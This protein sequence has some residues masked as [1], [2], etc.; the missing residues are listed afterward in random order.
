[1]AVIT[2]ARGTLEAAVQLGARLSESLGCR[3]VSREEV[4]E[5]AKVYGIEETGLGDM[6]FIDQRAP[7]FWHPFSGKR[8]QYLACFQTAL[9]DLVLQGDLVYVGHLAHLLLSG[10]RRV[11]RVRLAAPDGYRVEMLVRT[12]SMTEAHAKAYIREIDERRLRWSQFLYGVDW[13]TPEL[14]DMVLNPDKLR[15]ETMTRAV[16]TIAQSIEMQPTSYDREQLRSLR[17]KAV[18]KAALLRSPRTRG[19][20]VTIEADVTSGHVRVYGIAPNI[21]FE[22]WERDLRVTLAE[23]PGVRTTEIVP[24][25]PPAGISDDLGVG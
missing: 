7:S 12:R 25:E 8:N 4:Y 23:V 19:L 11:L 18:C 9:I 1:M 16:A 21:G 3:V 5:A 24:G 6:S 2:I 15:L 10:Y 13:R 17:L 14:Y 22:T 20:D